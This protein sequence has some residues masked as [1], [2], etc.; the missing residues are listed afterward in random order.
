[1]DEYIL[2]LFF[3]LQLLQDKHEHNIVDWY[4]DIFQESKIWNHFFFLVEEK[5]KER[6]SENNKFTRMI[7]LW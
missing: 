1:M 6:R 4:Q 3:H 2:I 7:G 5:Q